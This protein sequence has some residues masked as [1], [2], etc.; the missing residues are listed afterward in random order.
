MTTL[1]GPS[2]APRSGGA[3]R[4]AV[5]LLHGYGS[6][7]AD[8]IGLAPYWQDALPNA[9][10]VAPNAPE[11][12]PGSPGYQWF[13]INY[14]AR[15]VSWASAAQARETLVQYLRELWAETGIKPENTLLAGFSQGAMV[16]L[17]AGLSLPETLMGI[18][19]I[20]GAFRPPPGFGEESL[21]KP[22]VCLVHGD[23]DT[24]VEPRL[25]AE[26][27]SVLR[28]AG[29][30]VHYHVSRGAGHGVAP[31]GIVFVNQFIGGLVQNKGNKPVHEQ[32][33]QR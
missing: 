18:V 16:A 1:T 11:R 19:A 9:L 2:L 17:H 15:E 29:I 26:A 30:E 24:V 25:S 21:G 6:D 8:L 22:P 33:S 20:A 5:V 27:A 3:P 7:G 14:A 23:R 10:F 28:A 31:D 32:P 4:Q 12:C 13:A